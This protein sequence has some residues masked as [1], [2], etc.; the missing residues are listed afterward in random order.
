MIRP[1]GYASEVW[2]Y[3]WGCR[4]MLRLSLRMWP[5]AH[6]WLVERLPGEWMS[7]DTPESF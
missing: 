5:E 4:W 1:S 3:S 6:W 7:L 2:S